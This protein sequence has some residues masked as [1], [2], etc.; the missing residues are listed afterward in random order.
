M[1]TPTS[2]AEPFFPNEGTSANKR[3]TA[4]ILLDNFFKKDAYKP[5]TPSRQP[6]MFTNM[7]KHVS[8]RES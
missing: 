2:K 5:K 4:G 3:I 7:I 8:I 1:F 6:G